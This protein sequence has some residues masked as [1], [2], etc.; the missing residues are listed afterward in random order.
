[1]TDFLNPLNPQSN[2]KLSDTFFH[3]SFHATEG[4][5]LRAQGDLR[6]I[7]DAMI[8]AAQADEKLRALFSYVYKALTET[9]SANGQEKKE[10][11]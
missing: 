10:N 2:E 3:I 6:K 5:G 8:S 9:P 7:G 11:G 1:M 4:P